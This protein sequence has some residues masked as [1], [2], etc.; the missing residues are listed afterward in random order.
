MAV[1]YAIAR[2]AGSCVLGL[3]GTLA[4]APAAVADAGSSLG[5]PLGEG[6][7][8]RPLIGIRIGIDPGHNGGEPED[9]SELTHRVAD[10][11][12]GRSACDTPGNGTTSGY[13]EHEF[14]LEVGMLLAAELRRQGAIVV[15]TRT[16]DDGVGPCV[17]RRGTFAED[18]D[19]ELL[20]SLHANASTDA[21]DS[22]FHA[23]VADPPLSQSQAE[24]SHDLAQTMVEAL[25]D[26]GFEP[27]DIGTD[28]LLE[29]DDLATLNF[30][31]RPAVQLE[32][33]EMRNAEDAAQ[34]E[35]EE[36]RHAYADA[37]AQGVSEWIENRD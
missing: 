4:L 18:Q 24:P 16:E 8:D 10:G 23:V 30:S 36:G 1:R 25:V 32:L 28:G 26:G 2:V 27:S 6:L 9:P 7:G 21:E 14:T 13:A 29:R 12:G 5:K 15:M 20:L 34:M 3:A 17:D 11:R 22:G 35:S 19:V 31:R 33:G 37:L